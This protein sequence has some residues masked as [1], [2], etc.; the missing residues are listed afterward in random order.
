MKKIACLFPGIGYTC[1]KPLL[2]YSWKLLKGMDWKIVPVP[3]S[4]FPDKVKGNAEKMRECAQ[5]ALEQA[6]YML[7]ET[8]WSEYQKILFVGK[9]IGTV[10]GAAYAKQHGLTCRQILFTPVEATFQFADRNAIAFHGTA[11]PWARTEEIRESCRR[12]GIPLYETEGANHSLETGDVDR[13][14]REIR[15][16]MEI[17]REFADK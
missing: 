12:M 1:D 3:Y 15:K 2:Y 7:R 10:V 5:M 4:G 14:L 11:D 8:E 13:D 16:V 9:S 6:E 17:V